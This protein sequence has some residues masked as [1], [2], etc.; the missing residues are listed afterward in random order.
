MHDIDAAIAEITPKLV[1]L[2]HDL[3]RHPELAYAET[4]TAARIVEAL[5]NVPG[6]DIRT[7][8]AGTGILATLNAHREGP[9]VALRSDM[10]ALPIQ[11]A[12]TFDHKS[13]HKGRMHACGHDGHMAC[14]VGAARVLSSLAD[15]LPGRVKFVFQPAE[16]GGG[17]AR[18][19][20]E[21]GAL[22][23]PQVDAAF[24]FHGWPGIELGTIHAAP[25]PLLAAM[26][27]FEIELSGQGTHA[28]YPHQGSDVIV[29]AS[30]IVTQ[31]QTIASRL[32]DP[33]E[34][35]VVSVSAIHA[36]ETHNVLADR[37]K[38]LGTA[39]ALRQETHDEVGGL[40]TKLVEATAAA[41]GVGARVSY[42]ESYPAL[43]NDA[44]ATNLVQAA[45]RDVVGDCKLSTVPAPTMGAEDFAYYAQAV[46]STMWLMGLRPP[47]CDDCPK[48][49]QASFDFRDEVIPAAVAMH[50]RIVQR[51]L[52]EGL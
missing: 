24:A 7:G 33:M 16:E 22:V 13:E 39:R 44:A 25:G 6:L 50:C 40:I 28:A 43:V 12:N 42:L 17:G 47:G 27:A 15:D 36:G 3:H 52:G 23:D 5:G 18:R 29:T 37:C 30:H 10:D 11:E 51:F 41:F 35:V 49:H 45:A 20:I 2:R 14:L 34:P 48:L 9:C 19:M 32:T 21:A 1:E 26:S 4:R 8:L 38:M 46:P 31:L